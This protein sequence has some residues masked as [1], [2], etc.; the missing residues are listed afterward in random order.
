MF[1]TPLPMLVLHKIDPKGEGCDHYTT[2]VLAVAF[3]ACGEFFLWN[4]VSFCSPVD[5]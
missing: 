2:A 5:T 3:H 1:F 4:T